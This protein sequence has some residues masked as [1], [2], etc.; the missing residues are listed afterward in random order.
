MDI[1]NVQVAVGGDVGNT[2]Y[3]QGVTAAEIACLQALHGED[4]VF[5]IEPAG[6]IQ[7]TSKQEKERLREV[8]PGKVRLED[9]EEGKS[10]V[11]VLYPGAATK[12]HMKLDELDVPEHCFKP[13]TRMVPEA[14]EEV[15]E[16]EEP[17]KRGRKAKAEGDPAEFG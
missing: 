14:S 4:A 7:R 16:A 15:E 10:V 12:V 3:K 13:A 17:P 6:S 5:E 11:D 8:F 1:A 2:V 9:G